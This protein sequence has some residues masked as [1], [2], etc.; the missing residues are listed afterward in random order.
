MGFIIKDWGSDIMRTIVWFT[1]FWIYQLF[2]IPSLIYIKFLD[3]NNRVRER[4]EHVSKS[5]RNWARALVKM[6]GSKVRVIGEENIP[7]DE[8]VVFIS[9]HQGNFDIPILLG[10]INKSK[11]FISKVEVQ[12]LPLVST[13]MKYMNCVFMDRRDIRQSVDA[14]NKGVEYLKQGYSYVI[15]PEG[16]RSRSDEICDFKSGS[17]KLALKAGVPIVPV[18]IKGSY[19]IMEQNGFW[20]KPAS[21]EVII[22]TAIVTSGISKEEAKSIPDTVKNIIAE[23]L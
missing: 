15:F 13:W 23:N 18:T 16:S 1:Y 11:A 3:K 10:F 5:A 9:N 7:E 21:V 2:L 20:I 17:F 4:D 6:T 12:K 19:R 8:A 22:S 14:I